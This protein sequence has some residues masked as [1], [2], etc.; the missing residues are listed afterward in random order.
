MTPITFRVAAVPVPKG[1]VKAFLPKGWNRP[2][3]TSDAKGL[4]AW[5]SVVKSQAQQH[6]SSLV[7]GG[8]ALNLA[9]VLPRPKSHPK[10][11]TIAHTTRPDV[12]KLARAVLDA[13]IG[14]AFNDDGQVA[15]LVCTKRYGDLG[16]Q[17]GVVVTIADIEGAL[18]AAWHEASRA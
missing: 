3:L 11:K 7:T 2:V 18:E 12:D 14:V 6:C 9:F 5:A 16:E 1:S 10:T 15:G 13:L 8:V 4:K 17:P